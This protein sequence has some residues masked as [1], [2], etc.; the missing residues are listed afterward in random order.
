MTDFGWLNKRDA[1]E[2]AKLSA[3][4]G[5]ARIGFGNIDEGRFQDV[6]DGDL[7]AFIAG[8]GDRSAES[9]LGQI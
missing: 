3:L 7:G 4:M 8:L 2:A 5:A 6:S 9:R 1:L